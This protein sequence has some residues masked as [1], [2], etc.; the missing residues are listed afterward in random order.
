MLER[1]KCKEI[2]SVVR[3][4]RQT[5]DVYGKFLD[6]FRRFGDGA[7]LYYDEDS[8]PLIFHTIV[9]Y[10][11]RIKIRFLQEGLFRI[12]A[13]IEMVKELEVHMSL[14]NFPFL[15]SIEDVHVVCSYFKQV[16]KQ[17][18]EPLI[19]CRQYEKFCELS[20]VQERKRVDQIKLIMDELRQEKAQNYN[21][22][23]FCCQ[24]F[25]ELVSY[26]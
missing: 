20:E 1:I 26:E 23:R 6:Q 9:G 7:D 21:T 19:P 13:S 15:E 4:T 2:I 5:S 8:V 22:L 10:F 24:F 18:R 12:S 14:E 17:M 3:E 25:K 11:R 16:L